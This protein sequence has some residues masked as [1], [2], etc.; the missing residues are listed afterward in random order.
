M[1][2]ATAGAF[3][4]IKAIAERAPIELACHGPTLFAMPTSIKDREIGK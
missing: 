3:A 2:F 1:P 4:A